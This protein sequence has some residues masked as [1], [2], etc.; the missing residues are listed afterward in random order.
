[1]D[2]KQKRPNLYVRNMYGIRLAVDSFVLWR[3]R[4]I[5]LFVQRV[6]TTFFVR[7][8]FKAEG[9]KNQW[10]QVNMKNRLT[11]VARRWCRA[12][13]ARR[14]RDGIASLVRSTGCG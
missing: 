1:M 14:A 6:L 10:M 12:R 5:L 8:S 9:G 4:W 7:G 3:Y 2:K 11:I 13:V